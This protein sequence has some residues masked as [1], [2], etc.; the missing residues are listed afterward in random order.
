MNRTTDTHVREYTID[1][2]GRRL[3]DVLTEASRYLLGKD[4]PR[5]TRHA[6]AP[7]HVSIINARKLEIPERKKR[8]IYQRYSGYPG[9]R[10]EETLEHLANRLG[11][12]EVVRRSITGML[13]KNRLMKVRLKNLTVTD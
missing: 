10:K 12:S 4:D 3:G 1:A 5:F 7:A 2:D 8:E 13:P 11:Y 9:G 6:S